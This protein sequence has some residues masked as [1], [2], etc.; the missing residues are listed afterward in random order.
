MVTTSVTLLDRFHN[1]DDAEAWSTFVELYATLVTDWIR[2]TAVN[3]QDVPDALQEVFLTLARELPKFE[4]DSERS[5]G[6]WLR[7]VTR[8]CCYRFLSRQSP[9]QSANGDELLS[10]QVGMTEVEEAEYRR[11]VAQR[12]LKLMQAD[13]EETTWKACWETVVKERPS[14]EVA[15]E[16]GV[17]TN[18]VFLAKSRVLRRL[19]EQLDGLW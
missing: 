7:V 16:L 8:N 11:F 5:F 1:P 17:S 19:R 3:E 18:A 4:Y 6:G 9:H 12:A 2:R 14:A 15:T 10:D 13:F